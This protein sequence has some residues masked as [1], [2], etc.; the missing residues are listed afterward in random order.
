MALWSMNSSI[1]GVA[2][3]AMIRETAAAALAA[4]R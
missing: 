3:R 4:S 2:G 1:V